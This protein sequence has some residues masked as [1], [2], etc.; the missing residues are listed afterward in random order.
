MYNC[1]FIYSIYSSIRI[2][3][4]KKYYYDDKN[5]VL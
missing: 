1:V 3:F 5:D 2:E 4:A